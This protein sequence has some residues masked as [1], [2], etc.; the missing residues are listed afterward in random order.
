MRRESNRGKNFYLGFV[1]INR[2]LLLGFVGNNRELL[3]GLG[4]GTCI[5]II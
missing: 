3:L 2:E 5:K 1:G 4:L